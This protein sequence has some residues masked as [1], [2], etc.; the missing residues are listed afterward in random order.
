MGWFGFQ[1]ISICWIELDSAEIEWIGLGW[2]ELGW[3]ASSYV[4]FHVGFRWCAFVFVDLAWVRLGWAG[5][6]AALMDWIELDCLGLAWVLFGWVGVLGCGFIL[7]WC[8]RVCVSGWFRD[9]I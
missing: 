6:D 1:G 7:D 3:F 8:R 5:A 4:G 2:F 9:W